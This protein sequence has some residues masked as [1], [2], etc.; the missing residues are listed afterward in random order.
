MYKLNLYFTHFYV[1][2][3]LKIMHI[4]IKYRL[5]VKLN[6]IIIILKQ[7]VYLLNVKHQKNI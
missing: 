1:S 5:L 6:I 2:V 3:Y 4:C 7:Y